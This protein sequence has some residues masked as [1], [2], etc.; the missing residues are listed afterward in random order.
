M[1]YDNTDPE[2]KEMITGEVS[3]AVSYPQHFKA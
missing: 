3:M 2:E 1:N